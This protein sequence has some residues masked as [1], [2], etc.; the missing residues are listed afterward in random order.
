MGRTRSSAAG[1]D[2]NQARSRSF[3]HRNVQ[4]FGEKAHKGKERALQAF[5]A[6][7]TSQKGLRFGS[8][9]PIGEVPAGG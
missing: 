7:K 8:I 1:T 6:R 9:E 4:F 5:S 3:L 2:L